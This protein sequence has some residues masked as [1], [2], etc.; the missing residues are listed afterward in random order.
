MFIKRKLNLLLVWTIPMEIFTEEWIQC[1]LKTTVAE[2]DENQST[3]ELAAAFKVKI[4][5][6]M[7]KS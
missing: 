4:K 5:T 1:H 3:A 7:R 2:D 6:Y